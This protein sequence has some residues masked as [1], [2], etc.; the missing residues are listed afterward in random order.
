MLEAKALQFNIDQRPLLNAFSKTFEPGK[1]YA[2][3]G[4][5]GSGKSTLLKLLANQ[6]QASSGNVLLKGKP[7]KQW[8][9]KAF[10][11]HVAYLPQHLP[12]TDSLAGR[13]LVSFGRYPW[14]GLL[15]R[16]SKTDHAIV[17]EAMALTDTTQYVHRLVDSLS[18]GERQ[19]LWF[20]ML[21]AQKTP[22]L[23]LDEPLS[24]LDVAHQ[25]EM[26]SLIK[27][28]SNKL[29][30]G[31]IIVIHDINMAARFCDEI[32]ALH[33]GNLIA[34]GSVASIFQEAQLNS[35]FGCD[36]HIVD[37]PAGYPVAM[38]S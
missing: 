38:P 35:I 34:S 22:F 18:G 5:N 16:L 6:Q 24:A 2:L 11:Q 30:L 10:A 32:V 27:S 1:I 20:A 13:D 26:L 36:M 33:S 4:H 37:H 21:L 23:L 31:V 8:S 25:V 17:D 9:D 29:N 7:V 3:V 12:T 19:R 15:G 28:L 14:H